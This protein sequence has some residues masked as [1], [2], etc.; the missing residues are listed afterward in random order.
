MSIVG[1]N[2]PHDSAAGHVSGESVYIDDMQPTRNELLVDYF[3]SPFAHGK[4]RSLNLDAARKFLVWL[5]CIH[6]KISNTIFL[7][8]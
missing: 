4:V 3:G 1:K 6:I 8:Q 5:G 2:L 7:D